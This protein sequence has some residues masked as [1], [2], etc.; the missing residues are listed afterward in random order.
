M[1]T[2]VLLVDDNAMYRT[3]FKR[4][5]LLAN[6]DVAEAEDGDSALRAFQDA[7]PDVVVTDLSMRTPR[8]GLDVIRSL[9]QLDPI[10]PIVMISAVGTFEEGAEASALGATR[11]LSKANI[12]EHIDALLRALEGSVAAAGRSRALRA[13]VDS[14]SADPETPQEGAA[15]RLRELL[16]DPAL[17]PVVRGEAYDALLRVTEGELRKGTE[18]GAAQ[19]NESSTFLEEL[20]AL[21]PGLRT[22]SPDSLK[23]LQTAELFFH[24]QGDRRPAAGADFSRNIGFSYCFAV[25]NETK[26]RLRKRLQRFLQSKD[27]IRLIHSLLDPKK[28]QLDLLFHQYVLRLFQQVPFDFTIDNVRQVFLRITEHESR[29]KPDG[30]KA[31]GI[32]LVFFARDYS[33]RTLRE[34]VHVQNPLGIRTF[35]TEMHLLRFAHLLVALQHYRNPYIHPEISEMEKVSK[36][37]DTAIQCLKEMHRIA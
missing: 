4:N 21:I 33:V 29:Y 1:S 18:A 16:A 25:E 23:E 9:R 13:E 3:A 31:L 27:N 2:K 37:R 8:E 26:H 34:V 14:L 32:L 6:Y 15:A 24:Q 30:L 12:E 10:V 5:L 35:D 7:A 22:F 20:E 11:V 36:I 17:H 19:I 28:R